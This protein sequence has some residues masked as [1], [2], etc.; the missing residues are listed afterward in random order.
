MESQGNGKR[1]VGLGCVAGTSKRTFLSKGG[2]WLRLC[3]HLVLCTAFLWLGLAHAT[4]Y[5]YDANGRVVAATQSNGTTAQYTYDAVGNLQQV[6]TLAAGQLAIFTFVPTHGSAGTQVTVEGQGFSSTLANDSL[7]F[8]GTAATIVSATATSLV[9]DV[10]SGATTG[11]ISVTVSGQT[12]V[13]SATFTVDDTGLPPSISQVSPSV[14]NTGGTVIVSGAQLDPVS[15]ETTVQVGGLGAQPTSISETQL[16]IAPTTSG[17]VTVQTPYGQA[18]SPS[19]VIVLP[20]SISPS[21]V[22]SSGYTT[23]NGTPVNL[24]I[25]AV[26]QSGVVL[27]SA[28]GGNWVSL[29]TSAISPTSDSIAY[30][31]YAPGN[32]LVQQGTVSSTSPSIHLPVLPSSGVYAVVFSPNT[33]STQMTVAVTADATLSTSTAAT[34]VTSIPGQSQRVLYQATSGEDLAFSVN[35]ATTSPASGSITYTIYSPTGAQYT[36]SAFAGTGVINLS[37]LPLTGTYQIVVAPPSGSTATV[38]VEMLPGVTGTEAT[39]GTSKAY[40]ATVA[41]QNIYLSFTATQGQNLELTLNN[42]SITGA[43]YN[44]FYVYVYNAAGASVATLNCNQSNPGASC[45]Q[46]L[47]N[48]SAGTYSVV[49]TPNEGGILTFDAVLEPDVVGPA[50]VAGTPANVALGAGQVERLTFTG[51]LGGTVALNLSG[52]TTTPAGQNVTISVY[53]PDVGV[54][55]TTNAYTSTYS[56]SGVSTLNLTNLPVSGTYTVIVTSTCGIPAT[57]QLELANGVTGTQATN[58]TSQSYAA[59][60]TGQN[61]YLSFTATQGQNLELTLNNIS[62]TGATYNQFYVYVY[63]AAGAS[64]ATLN[65]NQSN[66]GAS[67]TQSLWNLSA[68]TYSVVVTPNEGGILTFDAVLEPDVVGPALVAGTPANVAL[69]AGQVERLTFTGTLGGTVALNLSGVTTTPAGQ[70]VTISVYRPD[71]GVIRTTNAYTSTYSSS[72]VSTLNLTNLPVSGTYTVIVTSTCGIPATAQLELANGV[73]GTQA[74]NGTSQSYAANQTGQNIYLSFTATQGQNLELTFNNISITG[75]TYNQFYVYVYNAAGASVT[76]F[77]CYQSNPGASCTQSLWN[78]SAGT[79]SVVVTPN[80][81]GILTFDAVLEPDVV[82]PALVA[83]TPANVALGAGQV[84]RL[85]FTGT[86]GGTVALNLSGVTTTPAGQNVTISVYRP[87]VGVIRTTNAY[88]S[89]YSSSGVSTLNLTNLPV[90]GTYTVIVTSTCGIP[91]T[92]QLELANGVTGTQ[93]TNGT[94]QSY[95]AN[96]TG[97]NIYLSFTATQGQNLE[98]TF[99]NISITGATYN[100]FYVYVYNAAGASV[101]TFYCYQS[102]PGA[103]CTQSLWNLSAGTYSVV[104]TPNDGGVLTFNAILQPDIVGPAISAGSSAN[105]TLATGQVERL[106]FNANVGDTVTLQLSGVTTVPTGQNVFVSIYRPDVGVIKTSDFYSS[107][108]TTSG[109]VTLSLS[110]L[111][112]GGTYTA[113]VYTS[114][115]LPATATVAVESDTAGT[116]P[117]YGTPTLPSNGTLT[118][119]QASAAGQ[120][121]TMTFNASQGQNLELTL[122]SVNV[123]GATLNGFNVS[124]TSPSGTSIASSYCY[125]SNPGASCTLPLWNLAAGTYTVTANPNWGGTMQFKAILAPDVAGPALTAGTPAAITLGAGQAERLTFTG[126]LGG[127]A[128]LEL[129]GVTTVPAGQAVYVNVYA[130]NAGLITPGDYYT[131]TLVSGGSSTLNLSNLP[132]TGTYTAVVYTD[133]GLP[134]TAQLTLANGETGTQPTNGT[135]ES[136]TANETGENVYFTFTATQSQNLELTLNNI[137]VTGGTGNALQ[138]NVYNATGGNVAG[139]NCYGSYPAASCTQPLWNLPAG[140]YNVVVTTIYGGVLQFDAIVAPDIVGPAL[141]PGT[142]A[143]VTLG[144]GQA[145]RLTFTGTLGGTAA[146][147]LSGVTTVPAGQ[148]VYVNV[149]AP[150]AGL[151]TPGDYYTYTLVSGGSSTLNLSN[152]PA[153]GTYTAVVYTDYGLPATAQLTLANGET[154]TQPTNGTSESYTA[155]ETGENVYFTFTATQSQNLELTLNNINVTGGTGNALQVNVYNATGGN[156]A[157]FNCYGSYPAAS[158]TQPLWNLPAGTYNVVVTTIYGG[159]LQFDAIVAPD[160]VGPALTPGTPES[161]TLGAG[162]AERLTFTGTLGG[163]AALELSG[164]T[165]VPAGQAVYVNVY[166]PNAGLITPGDY[167][168]YTLVSGGSS[169]LNLSNLPATGTYTAVVYTDYGL[170]ATAQLTLANGETGTQPTNG[171]SESYTAN[172]AGENVYFT[173]TATQSQNLELTLNNINVTGGSSTGFNVS[174]TNATGGSVANFS[175]SPSSTVSS[176]TQSLWN[177]AAGKYTV[178]A[179]PSSNSVLQFDAIVTSDLSGPTITAAAPAS[180]NLAAGQVERLKFSGTMGGT[181][182]LDLSGVTTTG[183]SVYVNVYLPNVG[184]ITTNN[185][186]T[187]TYAGSGSSTLNLTNLPVSGT[188][189]AI[190]YTSAGLPATAQLSLT[191]STSGTLSSAS[192]S[193]VASGVSQTVTTT[194][195]ATSG[196]NLELTLNDVNAS[197]ASTNGFEVNV[198]NPSGESVANFYCYASTPGGSCSQS[199]WNLSAGAYTVTASPIWGGLI[200]FSAMIIPD[201]SGPTLTSGTAATVTLG[202]GQVERVKFAG[203]AGNTVTL[204]LASISTTP[205]NQNVYV[206]VYLPTVGVIQT[207]DSYTSFQ[208][209]GSGT[210]TIP[211]LPATGTYTAI[212]ETG[213]GIPASAQLTYTQ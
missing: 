143:S 91:A 21:N 67:C 153:T 40:A 187:Y 168:T 111:P 114:Y 170:P 80:E 154:G 179:T 86:L 63:N 209:T 124:V 149:Y 71:V 183:Q 133:Y 164:V 135:S 50:L 152:L 38:Q 60:Q 186:Y 202:S 190:V 175:C 199:L 110:N 180:I 14:L 192:A 109:P 171:T 118:S 2:G 89:T 35:S 163:T 184:V 212:V 103:S 203:T 43:T 142:P 76:T 53:R 101:T 52:V 79:Y 198:A 200:S 97:Q 57:A 65:C 131:Y 85:T 84:E 98:L 132:A 41:G 12:V 141:T 145:E 162:Q 204:Q 92:A 156:V 207:D 197:S 59:N 22:V 27:F 201:V 49:V 47:W 45:T 112:A 172:E 44:Q 19:P 116:P 34:L 55:R 7:S 115:G 211:N 188:Y 93:A 74:T 72:G 125:A 29:Q 61:I 138:V 9:A 155:N 195:V 82:G 189:T 62:I 4:S 81:G 173:F 69:G 66:P 119:E 90:S 136:Y 147:E 51:T 78:L 182:A 88:T 134:A 108:Y 126:T 104:V 159:V 48:L 166:A 95:A 42:I 16:Q 11:P 100:Q 56:S 15:N 1:A 70:N 113:V 208:A 28:T 6:S 177:L 33:A 210:L 127:T 94:S 77:Y 30:A 165:T 39:N 13:S 174:V 36:A 32:V 96:Q 99:N 129:S 102:N 83:G 181:L 123:A 167:Y 8:N 5:V 106:T 194:F 139:F 213:T 46:S 24:S 73:T 68:G 3:K 23:P 178:V 37:G 121:V 148:A 10:P 146:L 169:T 205:A 20:T 17:Y 107:T 31:I 191:S 176:C 151:I 206:Y 54:I 140:T 64:V 137:N 193:F 87:D 157:G 120:N 117:T 18:T 196:Q 26:G 105:V 185:Y 150:N 58:G 144:A 130:P 122:N 25:P 128:A 160:I 161:V 75:A 158:C